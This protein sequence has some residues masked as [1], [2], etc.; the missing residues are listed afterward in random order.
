MVPQFRPGNHVLTFNWVKLKVGN[1]VVFQANGRFFIKRLTKVSS[2][3]F[4]AKGDNQKE[5]LRIYRFE[6]KNLVGR[7][8]L[9]Y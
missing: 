2:N 1:A 8:I 7:V 6:S 5:S 9:K 4:E 3:S